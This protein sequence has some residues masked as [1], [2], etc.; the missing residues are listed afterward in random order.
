M[1]NVHI[2][3]IEDEKG[4]LVDIKYFHHFCSPENLLDWPAPES[5][6]YPVY[7]EKCKERI[8]EVPLTVDGEKFMAENNV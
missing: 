3:F 7:C 8:F 5:L 6:D 4:D 1:S 2:E